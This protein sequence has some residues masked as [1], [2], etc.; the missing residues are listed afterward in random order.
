MTVNNGSLVSGRV[1]VTDYANLTADRYQ[2]LSVAQ[3]EPNLGPGANNTVLVI[4][5]N[6]TR[7][8]SNSL[9]LTGNVSANYFIGNGS[10][11]TGIFTTITNQTF[12]GDGSTVAFTLQQTATAVSILVTVNGITQTPDVDYLVITNILTF[13]TAPAN[14]DVIQVRFL[15]NNSVSGTYSNADVAAFLPVY[16]GNISAGNISAT[17][18]IQGQYILGNGAFLT[19]ISGGGGQ[20]ATGPIGATGPQ[21]ATGIGTN[22]ATGPTG[23]TGATGPQGDV[24]ATGPTGATGIGVDGATGPIGATGLQGATGPAGSGATTGNVTFDNI[25]IIGTGNLHLQPDPANS[26]A[27]LDVYLTGNAIGQ[28]IHIASN[29]EN[30]IIGRDSG[31]NV[32]VGASGNVTIQA[33]SGTPYVWTFAADGQLTFPNGDLTIISQGGVNSIQ[34]VDGKS[35]GLVSSGNTG[36][37]AS[38]WVEDYANVGT[39]NIA[40]VY[41]NPTPGSGIVRIAVGTNSGSGP[42]FWDFDTT[43]NLT[44]PTGGYLGSADV[45]GNGTML[46]GGTGNLTSVTSYYADAPGIYSTCLTANP[47]GTLNITTYGNGTGQLGQWIFSSAN[48]LLASQNVSGDAGESALLA[49]TRKIVNGQYSGAAYGYSAELAAGGTPSIAYTAS[50]EYVQSVRLTFA[51]ES[52]GTNPQWEQFDV[53][54][55]KSLDTPGTV[56]FVVSNRIK[57]RASIVDTVVTATINLANEIEI[58][59]NLDA[60]QTSG[61]SSFDA[62]EFGVMFN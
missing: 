58:S 14:A 57:A 22:G 24:G 51:V 30:V 48:L 33:D 10:L 43:G 40:A 5:T 29:S 35:V 47:D 62:V 13:T 56:N 31:A 4:T 21:G 49:G 46:T 16:S 59:L 54:A 53:V 1:P 11:L 61:W 2:F 19:G 39:S 20:G 52:V 23:T 6:N 17:G 60:G 18:N 27:Y 32:L 15:S 3:A 50:N 28:D 38:V 7:S 9:T 8:W 26:T 45:K 42:N 55:T 44:L 34:A 37:I 36:G 25:N 41:A 12:Q